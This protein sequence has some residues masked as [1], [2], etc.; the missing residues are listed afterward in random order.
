MAKEAEM[1]GKVSL[2]GQ[3]RLITD[4]CE[5]VQ[6]I[7][8]NSAPATTAAKVGGNA[9]SN[10]SKSAT[11]SSTTTTTTSSTAGDASVSDRVVIEVRAE[12]MNNTSSD[13]SVRPKGWGAIKQHKVYMK[14]W[15]DRKDGVDDDDIYTN[16]FNREREAEDEMNQALSVHGHIQIIE[17][18][19]KQLSGAAVPVFPKGYT[20]KSLSK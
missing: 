12:D 7:T 13:T 20:A 16:R 11:T 6:A 8:L 1:L 3:R 9:S 4:L 15:Q 10:V 5:Q 17:K 2:T 14:E 18:R 19:M